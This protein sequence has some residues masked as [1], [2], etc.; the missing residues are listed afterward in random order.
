[1][2]GISARIISITEALER[3][4]MQEEAPIDPLSLSL[5]EFQSWLLSLDEQG[6]AALLEELNS[7][8]LGL[9]IADLE[10]MIREAAT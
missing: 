10:R 5:N 1:M 2:P 3:K 4:R 8:G 7:D 9:D 6:R